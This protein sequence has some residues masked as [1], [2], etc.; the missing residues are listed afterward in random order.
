VTPNPVIDLNPGPT[1][2]GVSATLYVLTVPGASCIASVVFGGDGSPADLNPGPQFALQ[3]G[4]AI[5]PFTVNTSASIGTA[6]ATCTIP[7]Q[8][9]TTSTTFTIIHSLATATPAPTFPPT[10]TTVPVGPGAVGGSTSQQECP[11]GP[12]IQAGAGV[13]D[14]TPPQNSDVTV[15][16]CITQDG[17]GIFGVPMA[18]TW[19]FKSGDQICN[20]GV[21]D[22]KGIASCAL[23]IDH[24]PPGYT[25]VVD[26]D[27]TYQGEHYTAQTSFTPGL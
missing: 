4:L 25:V 16:G 19:H 20:Y 17:H 7:G 3:D 2:A 6:T 24:A 15:S 8:S 9:V 10:P 23:G 18:T 14:P 5:F 12:G 11:S 13:N 21:S 27:F 26:V 22:P 1:S